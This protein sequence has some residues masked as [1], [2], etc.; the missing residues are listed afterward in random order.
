MK[1][2]HK[3]EEPSQKPQAAPTFR[4][5]EEKLKQLAAQKRAEEKAKQEA[6][7][8]A[9]KAVVTKSTPNKKGA[10]PPPR[11]TSSSREPPRPSSLT[12]DERKELDSMSRDDEFFF[13]RL[14]SGVRPLDESKTGRVTTARE[15]KARKPD[16]V[17]AAELARKS[18]DEVRDHLMDLVEG[19]ARFEVSDDGRRLEGRR[20]DLGT[21]TFRRLRLGELPIDARLDLHGK[22]AVEAREALDLF[23][24]EKRARRD[25]VVLVIHG[26]GDHSP[27]QVG[28][29]RGEIAAW[30]S[31][32]RS[33][34]HVAA[35]ATA[36]ADDGG[37]GALYVL[38]RT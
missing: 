34:Q 17:V 25:R 36:R 35:F 33:S 23:L 18:D 1:K 12:A 32:G 28:V 38:L 2:K 4:P 22:S 14:M 7:A 27:A 6:A 37:E 8:A 24:R 19:A 21:S 9:T 11:T 31:Q 20:L 16:V 10:A 26:R 5:L 3:H 13:Q 29:L 15:V 30:L